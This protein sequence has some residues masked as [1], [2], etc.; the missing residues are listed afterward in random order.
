MAIDKDYQRQLYNL[1]PVG[2]AWPRDEETT[3]AKLLL[4]LATELAR[5]DTR[6]ADLLREAYPGTTFELLEDWERVLGLPDKCA[7]APTTLQ[8]RR[9]AILQKM[10][11]MGG[12]SRQYFIDVAA[13]FGFTITIT[14]YRPFLIGHNYIDDGLYDEEWRFAWLVNGPPTTYQYFRSGQNV[15]GDRLRSWGNEFLECI[16]LNLKPAHTVVRFAYEELP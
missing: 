15:S 8:A 16:I 13:S 4:A 9:N 2:M 14:E 1:L 10:G 3:M 7:G 5:V 6:I 12:Q 11:R